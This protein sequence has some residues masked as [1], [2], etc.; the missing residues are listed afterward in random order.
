MPASPRSDGVGVHPGMPSA[1][2][3][4]QRSLRRNPQSGFCDLKKRPSGGQ[5]SGNV[6]LFS[7]EQDCRFLGIDADSAR[8]EQFRS[9]TI[10]PPQNR[11]TAN[12]AGSS[13]IGHCQEV[14]H[15]AIPAD[16]PD[17]AINFY[18]EVFGWQFEVGWEY[19]TPQG[20]EKYWH[21]ITGDGA[22]TGINGGLTRRE[23]PGQPISVG[24]EVPA[25][26]SC[27]GLVEK[28]G[29]KNASGQGCSAWCGL[30]C[31]VSGFG[32]QY[33]RDLPTRS[34]CSVNGRSGQR[35]GASFDERE[36]ISCIFS[37]VCLRCPVS[38]SSSCQYE[39]ETHNLVLV[40]TMEPITR[41]IASAVCLIAWRRGSPYN[42]G[43][44]SCGN[45]IQDAS[46]DPK[47]LPQLYEFEP[48]AAAENLHGDSA[49]CVSTVRHRVRARFPPP[50][51]RPATPKHPDVQFCVTRSAV[52]SATLSGKGTYPP[53]RSTP[54][55]QILRHNSQAAGAAPARS[56]P[57]SNSPIRRIP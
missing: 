55:S 1:S 15:F 22:S 45:L 57:S 56:P 23:Y 16:V 33:L 31:C 28:C 11:A 52:T 32:G 10:R 9:A 49:R 35:I 26:D 24:I 2:F 12:R 40:Q 30:V 47:R 17:R 34:D 44:P 7:G 6:R 3:R 46:P 41:N 8:S 21:V 13:K 18:H 54:R 14:K 39:I 43:D 19:D 27:T 50:V 48:L 4:I 51:G 42:A 37:P 36:Y 20:R 29:G 53:I 25:V 38:R 5:S